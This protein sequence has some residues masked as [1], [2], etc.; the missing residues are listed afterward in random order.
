MTDEQEKEIERIEGLISK[1]KSR[2]DE[3]QRQV[4]KAQKQVTKADKEID[5]LWA[6]KREYKENEGLIPPAPF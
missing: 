6:M 5:D 4:I 2:R 1:A 3:L